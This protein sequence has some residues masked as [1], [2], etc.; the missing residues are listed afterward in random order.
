MYMHGI[1]VPLSLITAAI[2]YKVCT[3]A[4]EKK[5]SLRTLGYA[6][7]GVILVAS[8]VSLTCGI[9]SLHSGKAAAGW[10]GLKH[11]MYCPVK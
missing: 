2:G 6:V 11:K 5:G 1:E 8:V 4:S 3:I 9:Y 10:Q 7:G